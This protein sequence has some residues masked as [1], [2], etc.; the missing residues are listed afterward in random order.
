[1]DSILPTGLYGL[2]VLEYSHKYLDPLRA[3]ALSY[4]W[5]ARSLPLDL[6]GHIDHTKPTR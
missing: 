1:M 6:L 4:Q 2:Q 5:E 3:R